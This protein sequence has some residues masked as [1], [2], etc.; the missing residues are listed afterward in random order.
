MP[1]NTYVG[2]VRNTYK[3]TLY[4]SSLSILVPITNLL[5]QKCN[6]HKLI[7]CFGGF[8]EWEIYL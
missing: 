3:V 2:N 1:S 5:M 4:E 6:F 7:Q 8:A